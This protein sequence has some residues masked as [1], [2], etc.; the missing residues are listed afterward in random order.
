MKCGK[1]TEVF[2]RIVGYH[3]PV[4]QWNKGKRAEF[5]DREEFSLEKSQ[6]SRHATLGKPTITAGDLNAYVK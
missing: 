6:D 3:R 1:E 5:S 2:S 4:K